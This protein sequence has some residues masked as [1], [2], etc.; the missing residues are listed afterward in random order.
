MTNTPSI[1]QPPALNFEAVTDQR[2][3]FISAFK[4]NEHNSQRGTTSFMNQSSH[5]KRGTAPLTNKMIVSNTT[6]AR[7][8]RD[9]SARVDQTVHSLDNHGIRLKSENFLRSLSGYHRVSSTP[10]PAIATMLL[11]ERSSVPSSSRRPF[12]K[13]RPDSTKCKSAQRALRTKLYTPPIVGE[14]PG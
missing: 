10:G 14:M 1:L 13:N 12:R 5:R 8:V 9:P 3:G 11:Q 6:R 4:T 7:Q 2:S